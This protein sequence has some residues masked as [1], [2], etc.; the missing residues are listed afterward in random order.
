VIPGTGG[1]ET[2]LPLR[3]FYGDA[4]ILSA[5]NMEL[6]QG[7]QP[8]E[9][10]QRFARPVYINERFSDVLVRSG[11]NPVGQPLKSFDKDFDFKNTEDGSKEN[12]VTIVVGVVRNFFTGS[13]E[14]EISPAAIHVKK[15]IN[16]LSFFGY[17]YAYFHLDSEHPERLALVKQI[18]E[19][20]NP[21]MLFTYRNI[22]E[23]FIAL[24]QKVFG[25]ADLLLMYSLV[26]IILTCFGLFGMALYA[27]EQRT[28]EIGIRKVNGASTWQV[29]GLLN[30]EFVVW[31]GI[32]FL[33]AVPAAWIML[34]RWLESFVYRTKLSPW[35]CFL[36]G[37][38]VLL[39]ALLTV[40]RHSYRAASGNPVN[41]LRSE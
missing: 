1:S 15:E 11:E 24:N 12:P 3:E 13:L 19:K 35:L 10:F 16:E 41:V 22:Y 4:A 2:Y 14:E 36:A 7:M 39:I 33:F 21:G 32:A 6:L 27:T 18:W 40:C 31:A 37:L 30:R 5:F 8:E 28:K 9:A 34:N 23:D 20:H 25:L 38:I 17:A 29:M 26:S